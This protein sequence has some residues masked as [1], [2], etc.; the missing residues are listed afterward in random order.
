[1]TQLATLVADTGFF[2]IPMAK[3]VQE[4][5]AVDIEPKMLRML[6]ENAAKVQ[7]ENIHYVES[8]LGHI[9]LDCCSSLG[10]KPLKRVLIRRLITEF[11]PMTLRIHC[12]ITVSN[13]NLI[14]L[15]PENY[16]FKAVLK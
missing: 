10:G 16:A 7:L 13:L 5:F 15:N 1:M 3:Q 11:L 14:H 12:K 9:R 2:T 6:K 8:D 4:V